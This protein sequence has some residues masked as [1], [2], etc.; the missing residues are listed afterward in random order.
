MI[1]KNEFAMIFTF[2]VFVQLI[3]LHSKIILYLYS[4]SF[5]MLKTQWISAKPIFKNL[6]KIHDLSIYSPFLSTYG[7]EKSL[8]FLPINKSQYGMHI[9]FASLH[10]TNTSGCHSLRAYLM[11][12]HLGLSLRTHRVHALITIPIQFP[13]N[14]VVS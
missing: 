13:Q 2:V 8:L 7:Q 3:F 10:I 5:T 12:I 4:H 9:M 1:C 14:R 6:D 11:N